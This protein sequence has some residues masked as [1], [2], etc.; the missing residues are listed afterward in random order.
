[1]NT[2][3]AGCD[4][5]FPYYCTR[6]P[7]VESSSRLLCGEFHELCDP[8]VVLHHLQLILLGLEG[9]GRVQASR[10]HGHLLLHHLR[11]VKGLLS[12]DQLQKS[13][14]GRRK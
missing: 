13:W 10:A 2:G 4:S 14:S 7:P 12:Q 3:T 8:E 5:A 11:V 9:V 1:M 6:R